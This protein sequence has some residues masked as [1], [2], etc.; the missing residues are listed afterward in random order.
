MS[1]TIIYQS[2]LNTYDTH[3]IITFRLCF[4]KAYFLLDFYEHGEENKNEGRGPTFWL[5]IFLGENNI[6]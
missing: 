5:V 6:R 3:L 4:L 1:T 2:I